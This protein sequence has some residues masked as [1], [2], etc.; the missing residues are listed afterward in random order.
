MC[1]FVIKL[2]ERFFFGTAHSYGFPVD[3]ARDFRITVVHI[4]NQYCFCRANDNARGL[5][6]YIDAMGAE[7]ALFSGM[8]FRIYEYRIV[9]TRSHTCLA[10]DANRFVKVDDAILPLEHR[11]GGTSG[12]AGSV[13][14]LVT[15]RHLMRAARLRER[16]N[17]NV[18]NIGP[19]GG[20]GH[21][22]L[23]LARS[24]TRM[25]PDAARVVNDLR[26]FD[27]RRICHFECGKYSTVGFI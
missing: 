12:D 15:A 14:T 20:D 7:I 24:R 13:G 10:A 21:D 11:G 4:A 25:A 3:D 16:A 8:I 17:I 19:R 9:R 26:P 2:R 27:L 5:K 18:L 6:P 22:V 23:G 1:S